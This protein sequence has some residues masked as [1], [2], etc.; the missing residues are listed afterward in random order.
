[1]FISLL[2]V[3]ATASSFAPGTCSVGELRENARCEYQ[4][5]RIRQ[6]I[7][8]ASVI[9]RAR[10]VSTLLTAPSSTGGD[11]DPRVAFEILERIRVPDSL[12]RIVLRGIGVLNDDFNRDTV[13][14]RMVRPAGQR[15]DCYA[16]EYRLRAE[17]LLILEPRAGEL[18]P[19]W[20]PLAPFNEQVRGQDDPWVK[21]VRDAARRRK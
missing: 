1:M 8:G 19:H 20:K 14:Y 16:R 18:T 15:G 12:R 21:W 4:G 2:A 10:A 17:Y 3:L 7:D 11:G 6:F 9:V 13:P 5:E